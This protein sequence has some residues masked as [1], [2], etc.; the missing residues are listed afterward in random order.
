MAARTVFSKAAASRCFVLR[1]MSARA[2]GSRDMP[3]ALHWR[4]S[5]YHRPTMRALEGL[6]RSH[7]SSAWASPE[8]LAC[9]PGRPRCPLQWVSCHAW[10][11]PRC[12]PNRTPCPRDRVSET[13]VSGGGNTP[14]PRSTSS[15]TPARLAEPRPVHARELPKPTARQTRL[16][17]SKRPV[18]APPTSHS[19]REGASGHPLG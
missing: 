6:I 1:N 9:R 10:R 12:H 11:P 8:V 19:W 3:S 2:H 5:Y 4:I 17:I 18:C 16:P 7:A 15:P 14:M 13:K